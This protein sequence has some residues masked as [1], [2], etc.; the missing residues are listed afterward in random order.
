[1][2]K[3]IHEGKLTKIYLLGEINRRNVLHVRGEVMQKIRPGIRSVEF[4]FE[5]VRKVDSSAMAMMI[6]VMK[7]LRS[8][9][10]DPK[11]IGL[12]EES[13]KLL[14]AQGLHCINWK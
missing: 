12:D 14:K 2:M 1:M 8:K 4:H 3:V 5:N 9:A 6:V 7:Y 11:V 13:M 10:I